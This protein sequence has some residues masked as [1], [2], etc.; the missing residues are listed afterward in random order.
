MTNMRCALALLE[1]TEFSHKP[2]D[3]EQWHPPLLL[4]KS[5][6]GQ[7]LSLSVS[8]AVK[9]NFYGLLSFLIVAF[10]ELC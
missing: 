7:T 8:V 4:I 5:L 10:G 1:E 9:A 6:S 3:T 2:A